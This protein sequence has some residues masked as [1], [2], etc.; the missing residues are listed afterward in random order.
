MRKSRC[1]RS[2]CRPAGPPDRGA[3]QFVWSCALSTSPSSGNWLSH[4]AGLRCQRCHVRRPE[5]A[6]STLQ[7]L[8][9]SNRGGR[10]T[11]LWCP[12]RGHER[13][14]RQRR[15]THCEAV[16]ELEDWR[17][18]QRLCEFGAQ[19]RE[20][21]VIQEDI[22]LDFSRDILNRSRIRQAQSLPPLGER[23][24]GISKGVDQ[25]V[26]AQEREEGGL[27]G[28]GHL[29]REVERRS[30]LRAGRWRGQGPKRLGRRPE[31]EALPGGSPAGSCDRQSRDGD[32][33]SKL[34]ERHEATA[35]K[36]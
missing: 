8:D 3:A 4:L 14:C 7:D 36:F 27:R 20:H 17:C 16:R 21:G 2:R 11:C 33:A 31:D 22:S 6:V 15:S 25:S 1:Q 34:A 29:K 19:A 35:P 9:A 23:R 32:L 18:A 30:A 13:V 24:V 12:V 5:M 28:T 10:G 26:F